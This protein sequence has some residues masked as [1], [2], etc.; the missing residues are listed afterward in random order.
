MKEI[1]SERVVAGSRTYFFD[2]KESEDGTRYLVI[3]ESRQT[4]STFDHHCIMVFEEHMERFSE[5]F[6]QAVWTLARREE[7]RTHCPNVIEERGNPKSY[8][9]GEIRQSHPKAYEKWTPREDETLKTQRRAGRGISELA[10][11][12]RRQPSAIQSRLKKIGLLA[13]AE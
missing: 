2:V 10:A 1:F 3:S 6:D 13:E 11:M 9:V 7:F 8:N 5:I 12:L 4:G